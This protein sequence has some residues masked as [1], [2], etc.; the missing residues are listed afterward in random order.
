[1]FQLIMAHPPICKHNSITEYMFQPRWNQS[2]PHPSY[3][4]VLHIMDI[5]GRYALPGLSLVLENTNNAKSVIYTPP[6]ECLSRE[7]WEPKMSLV[8]RAQ[9]SR[10]TYW[11]PMYPHDASQITDG[12]EILIMEIYS[13]WLDLWCSANACI[14]QSKVR[15]SS[16]GCRAHQHVPTGVSKCAVN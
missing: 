1:M 13:V 11:F 6:D 7:T 12:A 4:H 14:I 16:V 5:Q 3:V 15:G 2:H 8:E 9:R 10:V